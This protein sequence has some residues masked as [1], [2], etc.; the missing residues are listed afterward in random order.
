MPA[1]VHSICTSLID[2]GCPAHMTQNNKNALLWQFSKNHAIRA[3]RL[4]GVHL[5][6]SGLMHVVNYYLHVSKQRCICCSTLNMSNHKPDRVPPSTGNMC[7]VFSSH[8]FSYCDSGLDTLN[9]PQNPQMIMDYLTT[10]VSTGA[11]AI[12]QSQQFWAVHSPSCVVLPLA[13]EAVR[14]PSWKHALD[15]LN[16]FVFCRGSKALF[17]RA[18]L[19]VYL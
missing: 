10:S 2:Q 19:Q 13:K 15:L 8:P 18:V 6:R 17:A 4:T 1:T 3:T 14:C 7:H 12:L 5:S 11:L 9:S 16:I